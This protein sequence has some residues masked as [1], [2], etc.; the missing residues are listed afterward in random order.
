MFNEVL[1]QLNLAKNEARIYETLLREGESS[2][3][4]IA[5][6]SQINRRNV[7]DSMNRL[8]EKGLVFE[9]VLRNENR[10]QAVDPHKLM[11]IVREKEQ[12]LTN[13]MP[14]L[15]RLYTGTP[16]TDQV[17]I[18]RGPE[19]WKN[20]MQDI[21]RVGK[22][23][24]FIGAKGG[25][26]DQRVKN[27]FP[28]FIR[29]ADRKG[30]KFHHL[31]DHEV[32]E[33]VPEIIPLIGQSYRFMPKGYSAPASVDI[34]GDHVNIISGIKLGGLEETFSVTV[35]VNSQIADAFRLWFKLIWD[36]C[37]KQKN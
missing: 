28:D 7:Y 17:F 33:T 34:F 25:W 24:Y 14:E 5:I 18:Y 10:Y 6:K 29:E 37:P 15:E 11:E 20:Y 13:I 27:F 22:D 3:G 19:G 4:K 16:N 36:F 21:L 12:M 23:A 35:I 31:F 2:I 8:I 1:E 9:I 30:I 26:L 32:K